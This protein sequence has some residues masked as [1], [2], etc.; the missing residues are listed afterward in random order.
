MLLDPGLL[1]LVVPCLLLSSIPLVPS[2]VPLVRLGGDCLLL[3]SGSVSDGTGVVDWLYVLELSGCVGGGPGGVVVL[4][5][6]CWWK[7]GS[8]FV[9]DVTDRGARGI[10]SFD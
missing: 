10:A 1:L 7:C 9:E 3:V 6:G 4:C 5:D 2:V 8:G